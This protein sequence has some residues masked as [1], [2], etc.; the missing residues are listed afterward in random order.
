MHHFTKIKNDAGT[1]VS[2]SCKHC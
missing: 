2:V 1:I